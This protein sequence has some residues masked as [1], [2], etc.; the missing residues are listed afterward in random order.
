MKRI[1]WIIWFIKNIKKISN[2]YNKKKT[3][4]KLCI[5]FMDYSK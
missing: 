4:K 5:E 2:N 3:K 1:W